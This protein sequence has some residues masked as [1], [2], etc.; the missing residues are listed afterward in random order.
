MSERGIAGTLRGYAADAA[1]A[2]R[3]APLEVA[4]GVATAIALSVSTRREEEE[5]WVRTFTAAALSLP[6][7]LGLSTL[8]ARR[9]IGA[10]TRWAASVAVL[11]AAAAFGLRVIDPDR[12]ASFLRFAALVGAGVMAV[13]LVGAIGVADG[14]ARRMAVWRYDA[15]L[16]TRIVTVVAYGVAL[17]AALA[18]AVA[19][20]T[21]LF[22]LRTPDEVFGDLAGAVFFAL[23]PWI[24]VGG[25]P[26]L[27]APAPEGDAPPRPVR[28]LGRYLYAPV[29]AVYLAILLAYGA[30]VLVTGE[31]PKNLLSPIILL[32]GLFGFVGSVLLEPLRRD[33]EHPGVERLIRWFPVP[34]LALLPFGLWAVWV[35]LDQYGW[36][37]FRYYRFA[38]LVA[39]TA[40]AVLGVARLVRRGEPVMTLVPIVLGLTL[41][42]ASFGPW[43]ASEV[44]RRSQQE[45]L[46]SGLEEAGLFARGQVTR[47]LDPDPSAVDTVRLPAE[48]YDR[49]SGSLR[50]LYDE[51]GPGAV[52]ELF[53]TDVAGYE[54][55]HALFAALGLRSECRQAEAPELLYASLPPEAPIAGLPAGTLYRVGARGEPGGEPKPPADTTRASLTLEDSTAVFTARGDGPAWTARVDLRPILGRMR[56]A[57]G[58]E[59]GRPGMGPGLQLTGAD[60]S[61]PLVDSTGAVRGTLIVTQLAY[62]AASSGPVRPNTLDGLVVVT[63]P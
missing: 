21:E 24:V 61:L 35:R 5:I 36:T 59:C 40:L 18:G 63:A 55:G 49:I 28:L 52:E 62:Q 12:E 31:A 38:L 23:V 27:I 20:V 43:G 19:A 48:T 14:G 15:R 2:F 57:G 29:L 8:H 7:L 22:D 11:A 25:I 33:P 46:R 13:S 10:A 50:Y 42:L 37:E 16:L 45:R 56:A 44:S 9:V 58:R 6:L 26:E 4:V 17:F 54:S 3:N 1:G 53:A 47:R 34:M 30:K 51:H 60:A 39:L 32:A 41:L